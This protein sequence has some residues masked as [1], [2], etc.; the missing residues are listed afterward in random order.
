MPGLA[1]RHLDLEARALLTRLDQVRPFVL[2]E[3]MVPAAALHPRAQI[4]VERFLLSGRAA[5]RERVAGFRRWLSVQGR[6]A[7]AEEQQRRFTLIR[8]SFNDVLSQLDLFSEVVTQRSESQNG[9][10]LSGLDSLARDALNLGLPTSAPVEVVTYLARGPGAAIRRARTRL[11]GGALSPVGIIRVPRERMVGFG[12]AASLV[13]ECGHQGSALLG[14]VESL[15]PELVRAGAGGREADGWDGWRRQVSEVTADLWA[16]ARLGT[17]ATLGLM[18]VVSLPR[19]FV[20]RPSGSDPHPMPWV[21]V[22]LSCRLGHALYPDPQWEEL[23]RLWRAM[24]PLSGASR[25]SRRAVERQ[26]RTIDAFVKLLLDHRPPSLGGRSI[27]ASMCFPDRRPEALRERWDDWRSDPRRIP[28]TAPT[29][30]FAVVGQARYAGLLGPEQESRLL[31][32]LLTGWA[33]RS[34]FGT[35][36]RRLPTPPISGTALRIPA[37]S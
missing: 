6:A 2:N 34:S 9:V 3:T 30:T 14:L 12:V 36:S 1:T 21:R 26:L 35:G 13:H 31:G 15:R 16:V 5:L 17:S 7:P 37:A 27:G 23:D 25:E 4:A 20:F 33:V 10:W 32:D 18:S 11:P 19:W 24:Y 22:L 8:M 28:R 29:L